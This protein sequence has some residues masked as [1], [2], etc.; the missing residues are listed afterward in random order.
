VF[1]KTL[2]LFAPKVSLTDMLFDFIGRLFF[3]R[4]QDWLRRRNAKIMVAAVTLGLV[5]GLGLFL[6]FRHL[7]HIGK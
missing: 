3:P 2:N 4:Q 6:V 7:S 5:F 1:E